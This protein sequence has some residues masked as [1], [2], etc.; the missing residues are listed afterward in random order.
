MKAMMKIAAVAA[1]VVLSTGVMS[2]DFFSKVK[3]AANKV[4]DTTSAVTKTVQDTANATETTE[5][6]DSTKKETALSK[7]DFNNLPVYEV[8][9]YAITDANG[10]PVLNAD[11]TA[12][13]RYLLVDQNGNIRSAEAVKAQQDAVKKLTGAIIKKVGSG[14]AVGALAGFA[15]GGAKGAAIGAGAGVLAGLGLSIGDMNNIRKV[16]KSLGQ[17]KK[18]VEAYQ[19]NFTEEGLPVDAT[20]D[21]SKVKDLPIASAEKNLSSEEIAALQ[22]DPSFNDSSVT[23]VSD[24]DWAAAVET[25]LGA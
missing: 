7:I 12:Q 14:A 19:K 13:K 17:Q 21:L 9:E 11:G 8:K 5:A 23:G 1:C 15:K 2:A 4:A 10:N 24:E 6:N 25:A 20:A 3:K 22:N 16:N 18:L